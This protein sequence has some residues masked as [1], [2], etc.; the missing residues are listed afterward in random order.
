[1]TMKSLGRVFCSALMIGSAVAPALALDYEAKPIQWCIQAPFRTVGAVSGGLFT[2]LVSG[3]IDGGF[4]GGLKGTTHVAGKYGDDMG[5]A[6]L[7]A[8]APLGAPVGG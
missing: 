7:A 6:E 1:M 3:P 5:V 8:A 4:H 2:G